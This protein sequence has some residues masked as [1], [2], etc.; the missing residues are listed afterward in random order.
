MIIIPKSQVYEGIL[1]DTMMDSTQSYRVLDLYGRKIILTDGQAPSSLQIDSGT[2]LMVNANLYS[3]EFKDEKTKVNVGD[4]R[5][6]DHKVIVAAGPCAVENEEQL[7]ET[8]ELVKKSG[9]NMLRGGAFKPRTSPYSFQGLGVRGLELLSKA[10]D[11]TGLPVVT[12][13]LDMSD[14]PAFE[15]DVDMIQVGARNAQNFSLLRFL[16]NQQKP[17]LLKNGMATTMNEW[18]G[19]SEYL[20]SGGNENVVLCYRG[21]RNFESHTRFNMDIG[22]IASMEHLTHLPVCADPS[23]PAGRRDIVE[24]LA[25]G[26]VASG[27]DM[28]EVEVHRDPDNALSDASQ[29]LT[30]EMFDRLMKNVRKLE[31]IVRG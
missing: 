17:V 9:A 30:P 18:L 3:R 16:G 4:V 10:K 8:A 26:A 13:L 19:S 20:L 14:F 21:N 5:I 27:A 22:S 12:E 28:L 23:H 11:M 6:G 1:R 29:Q 24:S 7:L 15:N 31:A 2:A 25:L